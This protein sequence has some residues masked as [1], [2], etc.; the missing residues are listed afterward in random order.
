VERAKA[1]SRDFRITEENIEAVAGICRR[2]DGIPLALEL[3]AA[4]VSVFSVEE[5]A[6]RLDDRFSLL[7]RGK[8]TSE[9]R[10]Q[11]LRNMMSWSWDLL[12][13]PEQDFL[14]RLSVF[15][16]GMDLQAVE[17]VRAWGDGNGPEPPE[18]LSQLVK[19][20]FVV[21]R[22][23]PGREK[24]Y[25]LLETVRQYAR[26]QLEQA[27]QAARYQDAHLTYYN[28]AGSEANPHLNG[29]EQ[30]FY[31]KKLQNELDNIRAALAWGLETDLEAGLRLVVST[32]QFWHYN[33]FE[34]EMWLERFLS[35]AGKTIPLSLKAR[36]L[37]LQGRFN[38]PPIANFS[39]A[40]SLLEESLA[41][42][43]ALSDRQGNAACLCQLGY[44]Y[45][46]YHA[47][48]EER[49]M[50]WQLLHQSLETFRALGDRLGTAEAL[51]G[52]ALFEGD[53]DYESALRYL[54]ESLALYREAG[55][56]AR[57][58]NPLFL[59]VY[60]SIWHGKYALA[61]P[62]L[63]EAEQIQEELGQ[64]SAFSILSLK[65]LLA[66]RLGEYQAAREFQEKTLALSR[67]TGEKYLFNWSSVRLGYVFL[68]MGELDQARETLLQSMRR[69]TE[70][71]IFDGVVYAIEGLASLNV[72]L[73][74]PGKAARL[75]G[76]ADK[77][78]EELNSN[79]PPI[80]KDDVEKEISVIIGML[81]RKDYAAA[82]DAGRKM[83]EGEAMEYAAGE[84]GG[85][86]P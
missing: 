40:R 56:L 33:V 62:V 41:I 72:T 75:F 36:A 31:L 19:K 38:F 24:R 71:G 20:S 8:R 17:A 45:Y 7:V 77:R 81:G 12:A 29:K 55:H 10:H 23:Q 15:A 46:Y 85:S 32:W 34:G 6:S 67:Q 39:L 66:Y 68:K 35:R 5:I 84:N 22:P 54:E 82:Y 16:G 47:N 86:H 60:M 63:E 13:L 43:Q 30:V 78:R 59:L 65:G 69:F 49:E 64:R 76:W 3:A 74:K 1:V 57:T 61:G 70:T 80:E 2:L 79:R 21:A 27:G 28:Q 58:L 18:L 4:R 14:K 48:P 44:S 50:G 11:T 25:Y 73:Q 53:R 37:Y 52:L 26:E 51:N 42:Y 9:P 83:T